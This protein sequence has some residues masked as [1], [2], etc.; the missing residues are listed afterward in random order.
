MVKSKQLFHFKDMHSFVGL[1]FSSQSY[2]YDD[3]SYTY[4]NLKKIFLMD[5]QSWVLRSSVFRDQ[6]ATHGTTHKSAGNILHFLS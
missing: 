5:L 3:Q 6:S 1:Q 2:E 4:L